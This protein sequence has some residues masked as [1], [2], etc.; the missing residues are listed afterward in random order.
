MCGIFGI[1]SPTVVNK[2]LF[3]RLAKSAYARGKDSSGIVTCN[4]SAYHASRAHADILELL[5]SVNLRDTTIALGHGRLMT[6]GP[7]DNQP[8]VQDNLFVIHNGIIVNHSQIWQRLG[9]SPLLQI[10]T[11]VILGLTRAYL[12]RSSNIADLADYIFSECKGT[13][14]AAIGMPSIGK[15]CLLSNNG[16]L[17]WTKNK[18]G[19]MFASEEYPLRQ[20]AN[21]P[22]NQL[23]NQ[24]LII[25]IPVR[26]STVVAD[27]NPKDRRIILPLTTT[28]D[29]KLLLYYASH[30]LQR[31]SRCILPS[32]M[33]F[34]E[35]DENGVCNYCKNYRP[36]NKPKPISEIL[37]LLENYRRQD[38][39][40]CIVPFSG[41]RDSCWALH[42]IRKELNLRPI[43]YTYDWGMVTD[44]ARRNISR[45]CSMLGV[46]NI[47]VAADIERKRRHISN[48]LKTWLKKPELGMI[49]ILTA[50]DK[51]FFRYIESVKRQTGV[52]LNLWGVNPLE[53]TH[54]KAGFLGVKPDFGEKRVY[55][56]GARKQ[57]TYQA[58]R[59]KAMFR[60]PGYFNT[61]LV[62]TLSGEYFRSLSA[63]S[64]YY[65]VFDYWKWDEE[66]C[67]K[68]LELYEWESAPD[69]KS[70][71]R[72]GDG[73]AA[74]YNYIYYTVAG[75]TE[76][77]T[78]RSNQ[79][80]EG[81]ITR[82]EALRLVLDE[83]KPRYQNIRWYLD[84]LGFEY[85]SVISAINAI[86]KMYES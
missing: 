42:L 18:H 81:Q 35:F 72:I 84:V 58:Q 27:S 64:H 30:S 17:Y 75:F 45:M 10:D 38:G 53:V 8:V 24:S 55:M 36:R 74:F 26:A 6:N 31:C 1:V 49:S 51:H 37:A 67:D 43:T 54:F 16:S 25:D 82:D 63:K 47:I 9:Q 14:S 68:T 69:T 32:S 5:A 44:L 77:D 3:E 61:S 39:P 79:I 12:Q 34:I 7:Q 62:D 4:S 15:L 60:N 73:T 46:E 28:G 23:L 85:G 2:K 56:N 66:I 48:N 19:L 11:E 57:L 65:H 83:N 76:H 50:G 70:T 41:G 59:F 33:P 29:E 71:W 86:P 13:I 22:I 80:R 78:F 52:S 20:I 40:E 21:E